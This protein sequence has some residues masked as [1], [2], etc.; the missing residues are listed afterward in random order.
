MINYSETKVG[1]ILRVVGVGAP[2]F[3]ANGDLLRVTEVH[4]NSVKVEDRDG[5]PS[6]F[7]FNCGAARLERTEWK[8]DFPAPTTWK[9]ESNVEQADEAKKAAAEQPLLSREEVI[10]ILEELEKRTSQEHWEQQQRIGK[11]DLRVQLLERARDREFSIEVQRRLQLT[12]GD[13]DSRIDYGGAEAQE[14][15]ASRLRRARRGL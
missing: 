9:G 14:S 5:K 10:D 1:D 2:G 7:I 3:A 15:L 8:L 13:A 6:E 12:S 4:L 11:L